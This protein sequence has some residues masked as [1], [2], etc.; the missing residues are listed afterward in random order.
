MRIEDVILNLAT[1]LLVVAIFVLSV[2]CI[3]LAWGV[4]YGYE[5][6]EQ[7]WKVLFD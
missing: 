6:I 4:F 5:T 2:V 7:M 3:F 1:Y